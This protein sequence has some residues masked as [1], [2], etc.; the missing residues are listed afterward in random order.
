MQNEEKTRQFVSELRSL[1]NKH[2]IR[3]FTEGD[4]IFF[5]NEDKDVKINITESLNPEISDI[6]NREKT[7]E[8]IN[9]IEKLL[10]KNNIRIKKNRDEFY[11]NGPEISVAIDEDL[12]YAILEI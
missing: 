7:N 6:I 2:E 1:M 8:F 9:S 10:N 4:E 12:N 5:E 11:L 3:I